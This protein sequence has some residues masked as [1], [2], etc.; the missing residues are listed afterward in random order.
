MDRVGFI[1]LNLQL[2]VEVDA[3]KPRER[4]KKKG[5]NKWKKTHSDHQS[6]NQAEILIVYF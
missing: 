1:F 2:T 4:E 3:R 6:F 5:S